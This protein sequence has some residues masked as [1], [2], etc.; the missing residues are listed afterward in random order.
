MLKA[1]RVR[2]W[3]DRL[4][5]FRE[6]LPDTIAV[7]RAQARAFPKKARD[8]ARRNWITLWL[9]PQA[10]ISITLFFHG[11]GALQTPSDFSGVATVDGNGGARRERGQPDFKTAYLG[12]IEH[13]WEGLAS[14]LGTSVPFSVERTHYVLDPGSV[15]VFRAPFLESRGTEDRFRVLKG[16][17]TTE[18]HREIKYQPGDDQTREIPKVREE[19]LTNTIRAKVYPRIDSHLL[20]SK[21]GLATI[22]FSWSHPQTGYVAVLSVESD[23]VS[24]FPIDNS[25]HVHATIQSDH[26]YAWQIVSKDREVLEGPFRFQI[27]SGGPEAWRKALLDPTIRKDKGGVDILLDE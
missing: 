24:Y 10:V 16:S 8:W 22:A 15:V 21:P 4:E 5:E 11:A 14:D 17:V 2:E 26:S 9:A 20:V 7:L 19:R 18:D 1:A 12:S 6:R 23:Q 27:A 13:D 25:D 3:L